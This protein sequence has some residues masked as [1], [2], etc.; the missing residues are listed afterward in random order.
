MVEVIFV[1][2]ESLVFINVALLAI[3][4]LPFNLELSSFFN[5]S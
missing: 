4:D 5:A 3:T 2:A 1:F